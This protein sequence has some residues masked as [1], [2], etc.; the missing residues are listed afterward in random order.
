MGY[1]LLQRLQG[2]GSLEELDYAAIGRRIQAVR[3][4]RGIS[5]EALCNITD[6]SQSHVSHI[7]CGKTKLSLI[8]IVAIANA[9]KTTTDSLL[10]DNVE[11]SVNAYDRDFKDLLE[12]CTEN[13]RAFLLE[14]ATQL[15]AIFRQKSRNTKTRG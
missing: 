4:A 8:A 9:L 3:K 2:G 14:S 6:L 12:D 13:E 11:I 1:I 10:Y 15:K 7:E 5:Q